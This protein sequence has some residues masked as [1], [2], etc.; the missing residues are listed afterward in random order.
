MSTNTLNQ[1]IGGLELALLA[2]EP[3]MNHPKHGVADAK[4]HIKAAIKD[5]EKMQ[6][7]RSEIPGNF[8]V[9]GGLEG[10]LRK[11]AIQLGKPLIRTSFPGPEAHKLTV[12]EYAFEIG[13]SL[14][15]CAIDPSK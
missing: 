15:I 11:L 5:L 12:D 1:V 4:F 10:F 3:Q 14:I 7:R 8:D 2:L 9:Y 6:G 13:K